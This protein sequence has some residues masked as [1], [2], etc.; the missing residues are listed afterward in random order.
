MKLNSVQKL[1]MTCVVLA[2]TGGNV[3]CADPLPWLA[4]PFAMDK[5]A[6]GLVSSDLKPDT[7]FSPADISRKLL[8]SDVVIATLCH[9]P[10]TKAAYLNLV[11]QASSYATNY[12]AYFPNAAATINGARTTS[13]A[14]PRTT[15]TTKGTGITMGMTLYDFGQR[16]FKLEIAEL[17][18]IAAGHS[19]NSTLQGMIASALRGYYQLLTSQN[20][21]DVAKESERYAKESYDAAVLRH[22][23]GQ[24]PLADELQARGSYSQA[25][26]ATEQ[27]ENQLS[28]DR[29]AL[30]QLIGLSANSPVEVAEMDNKTLNTDPFGGNVERL[31]DEAKLKRYDLLATRAQIRGSEEALRSLKRADLATISATANMNLANNNLVLPNRSSARSQ[32]IG[33]SVNIPIFTGFSQTY[34][35]RAAQEQLDAQREELVK[36]ELSVEQD[37]WNSWHN[38]QTAKQSWQTSQELMATASQLKDVALGRYKEGLGTILDVL[39]AQSQY[40][41]ALQSQLQSRYNL[42]TS[43]VDLVRAVGTLNLDTMRPDAPTDTSASMVAIHE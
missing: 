17:A 7:C 41:N 39:N 42:F 21:V 30:A 6:S 38:F 36:T 15:S 3:A 26:L 12:S 5:K 29:A 4:D 1:V 20:A 25:L 13:F 34:N 40:S 16:E 23:I 33:I 24:V 18:L 8:F 10:D 9:N 27:A 22:R 11:A 43:R 14:E 19:Y 31:M 37:V 35:E 32:G 2:A 28:L